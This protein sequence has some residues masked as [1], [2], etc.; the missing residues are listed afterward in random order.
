MLTATQTPRRQ[1]LA[2]PFG[3]VTLADPSK[4]ELLDS[5]RDWLELAKGS[6][7]S[8]DVAAFYRSVE[9][10]EKALTEAKEAK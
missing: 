7:L 8:G 1:T 9:F 10:A 2:F 5:A 3:A 4:A 6:L